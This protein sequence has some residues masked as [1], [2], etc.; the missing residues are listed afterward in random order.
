MQDKILAL[1]LKSAPMKIHLNGN[2]TTLDQGCHL[3]ELIAQLEVNVKNVAVEHNR[4]IVPRGQL[5]AVE[6]QDGD[7]VEVVEFIG[8]G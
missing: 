3:A 1:T 5:A 2:V 4:T 6:L 7:E 8:G